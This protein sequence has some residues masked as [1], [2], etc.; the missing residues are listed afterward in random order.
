VPGASSGLLWGSLTGMTVPRIIEVLDRP[1][2]VVGLTHPSFRLIDPHLRRRQTQAMSDTTCPRCGH[3]F[4]PPP[5][6]EIR[7]DPTVVRWLR[8]AVAWSGEMATEEVYVDYLSSCGD[9][10]VSRRRFVAD[11]A[12]LGIPEALDDGTQMLVRE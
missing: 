12:Y 5:D 4:M 8:D 10:P 3:R 11:L 6:D 1:K 7:P 9:A 2:V